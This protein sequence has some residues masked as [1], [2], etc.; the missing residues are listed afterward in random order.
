MLILHQFWK[1]TELY[2]LVELCPSLF[3]VSVGRYLTSHMVY[4]YRSYTDNM[5]VP[6]S[7][8]TMSR[9]QFEQFLSHFVRIYWNRWI[10]WLKASSTLLLKDKCQCYRGQN[11]SKLIPW[12]CRISRCKLELLLCYVVISFYYRNSKL[13]KKSKLM[14]LTGRVGLSIHQAGSG[15]Y[16]ND[17]NGPGWAE[18]LSG[19]TGPVIFSPYRAIMCTICY[20]GQNVKDQIDYMI[21]A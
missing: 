19:Q 10:N 15:R 2:L 3:S 4:I 14:A 7:V 9:K 18:V 5:P 11:T 8:I 20:P 12:C 16:F 6:V 17:L 1:K 13:S 21:I